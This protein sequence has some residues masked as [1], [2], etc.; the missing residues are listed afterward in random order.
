MGE[1]LFKEEEKEE[2]EASKL[3]IYAFDLAIFWLSIVLN[4]PNIGS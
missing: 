2:V 4:R 1:L 3:E